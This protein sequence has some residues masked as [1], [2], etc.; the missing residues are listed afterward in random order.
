MAQ[1]QL[2]IGKLSALLG[3]DRAEVAVTV[4]ERR[5]DAA[6]QVSL[7]RRGAVQLQTTRGW[8]SLGMVGPRNVAGW[9]SL[10]EGSLYPALVKALTKM[11]VARIDG[12]GLTLHMRLKPAIVHAV[13]RGL[14][15]TF[16]R[17]Y[18]SELQA[19]KLGH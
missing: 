7:Q 2:T 11:Q 13:H 3:A 10:V 18:Q 8:L 15:S 12:K 6:I 4:R 19:F 14:S 9:S 5:F 1:S 17:Q 16:S